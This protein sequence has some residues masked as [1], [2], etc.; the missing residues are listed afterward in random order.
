MSRE[1]RKMAQIIAS[2]ER[3]EQEAR[4]SGD[5]AV[6]AQEPP[7]W[8]KQGARGKKGK[9]GR[10]LSV[11]VKTEKRLKAGAVA[12]GAGGATPLAAERKLT[13]KKRWIQLWS[14]QLDTSPNKD[15]DVGSRVAGADRGAEEDGAATAAVADTPSEID[16]CAAVLAPAETL[17]TEAN[18]T[19]KSVEEPVGVPAAAA[20]VDP[21]VLACREAKPAREL[22]SVNATKRNLPTETPAASVKTGATVSERDDVAAAATSA[23][24]DLRVKTPINNESSHL[25]PPLERS[26][27]TVAASISPSAKVKD[28]DT[29][30][31]NTLAVA[32]AAAATAKS[33]P[34]AAATQGKR[35]VTE[36]EEE[37]PEQKMA[38]PKLEGKKSNSS[39]AGEEDDSCRSEASGYHYDCGSKRSLER[40]DESPVS[41][42]AKRRA[43]RRRKRKSNWDVGDPRRGGSPVAELPTSAA[44]AAANQQSFAKYPPTGPPWRHSPSVMDVKPPPAHFQSTMMDMKPPFQ[45]GH[46]PSTFY[47]NGPSA[48][49]RR[50]FFHAPDRSRSVGRS[51]M[52][53]SYGNSGSNY[54]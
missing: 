52:R 27:P 41:D 31:S 36:Q 2:I 37:V 13:P 3:M 42:E 10:V 21:G 51:S 53:F 25:S 19:R 4:A 17:V 16:A 44:A 39:S 1:E 50:G 8:A 14:A 29:P 54:R 40:S 5:D 26:S 20:A 34:A 38:A 9:R 23:S 49:A 22:A 7:E 47:S 18:E 46:R 24:L 30:N 15:S 35:V 11:K 6:R 12:V 43:E 33:S 32:A 45:S 28:S 48:G